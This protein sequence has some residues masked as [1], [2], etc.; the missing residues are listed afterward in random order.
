ME[1]HIFVGK[2]WYLFTAL[3]LLML[4]LIVNEWKIRRQAKYWLS[5]MKA[6]QLTNHQAVTIVD[7]R[8]EKAYQATA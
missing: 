7:L 8:Q 5:P 6:V 4:A 1:F 3:A 2:Y